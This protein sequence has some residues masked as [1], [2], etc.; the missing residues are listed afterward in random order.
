VKMDAETG[1]GVVKVTAPAEFKEGYTIL[2]ATCDGVSALKMIVFQPRVTKPAEAVIVVPVGK[3]EG[4]RAFAYDANFEYVV[5]SAEG[6][7][8]TAVPDPE[9]KKV[10]FQFEQNAGPEIRMCEITVCPKNNPNFVVTTFRVIQASPERSVYPREIEAP[11]EGGVF[12]V[13]LTASTGLDY[14]IR[15]DWIS[16]PGFIPESDF[17]RLP[18][19]V[20]PL[21]EGVESRTGTVDIKRG[22]TYF[23]QITI[24]QKSSK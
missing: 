9:E 10:I 3:D 12:D 19:H 18:I 7:W 23:N 13:W 17:V 24:V 20:A 22:T 4:V 1:S 11:A 2:S 6:S 16:T 15:C 5:S 14:E 21:P 8:A